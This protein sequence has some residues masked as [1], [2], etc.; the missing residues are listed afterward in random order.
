MQKQIFIAFCRGGV[1]KTKSKIVKFPFHLSGKSDDSTVRP[2][3]HP[4]PDLQSA[5]S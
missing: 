4:V 2:K 3:I 1:S 5:R